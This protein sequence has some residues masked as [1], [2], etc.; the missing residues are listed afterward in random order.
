MVNHYENL[1]TTTAQVL[2][3]FLDDLIDVVVTDEDNSILCQSLMRLRFIRQ[4]LV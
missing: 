2:N 4:S 3:D 1:F